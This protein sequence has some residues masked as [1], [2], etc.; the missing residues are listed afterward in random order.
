[1]NE[2]NSKKLSIPQKKAKISSKQSKILSISQIFKKYKSQDT[3]SITPKKFII[4]KN[5]TEENL[6][7][8]KQL[9][10][11]S[12]TNVSSLRIANPINEPNS[13]NYCKTPIHANNCISSCFLSEGLGNIK[14][15]FIKMMSDSSLQELDTEGNMNS[16]ENEN[17]EDIIIINE[18]KESTVTNDF[19]MSQINENTQQ[20]E[21]DISNRIP[22]VLVNPFTLSNSDEERKNNVKIDDNSSTTKK[23]SVESELECLQRKLLQ[24]AKR[25]DKDKV[26]TILQKILSNKKGDINYCDEN[27]WTAL[28]YASDEGCLKIVELLIKSNCDVNALTKN[29]KTALHLAS[30]HGYFDISRLL[31]ENGCLIN[32]Y[33]VEKNSPL[34]LCAFGGHEELLKFLLEKLPEA[35]TKNIYGNTPL[36]LACN[37]EIKEIFRKYLLKKENIYHRVKIHQANDSNLSQMFNNIKMNRGGNNNININIQNNFCNHSLTNLNTRTIC[38]KLHIGE[39]VNVTIKTSMENEIAP[40]TTKNKQAMFSKFGFKNNVIHSKN[41]STTTGDKSNQFLKLKIN[42]EYNRK[43]SNK[44]TTPKV[45]KSPRVIPS[46]TSREKPVTPNNIKKTNTN[47]YNGENSKVNSS[48]PLTAEIN[49]EEMKINPTSFICLALLGRGSFGEVYLVKKIDTNMLYAMKILSKNRIKSQNLFKYAMAERNVL[50]L[51][52]HPFIVKL[53]FAFQTS[54]KLFLILD[55]CSNGDL[56]RHLIYEKRFSE[57]RAKFYICE[58]LL[59]LEDLHQRGIIFRDLKPDNVV[60]DNEGH[61]KLTD[62]GLSKEG[63][64][65]S[66]CAK[67][68]CGSIAYLAPEMLKRSGHGKAV[69]WYLLGVLFYEML[70]GIPPFFTDQ[71]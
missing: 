34:H 45:E 67:S 56:S 61:A 11:N 17:E 54:N 43:F 7:S 16:I 59:A 32:Q 2:K 22:N 51:T 26:A 20:I 13:D 5:P 49:L 29:R 31:I 25:G 53:N 36:D 70:V 62:F 60:L 10:K 19:Y 66:D 14:S 42:T 47:G 3:Y 15:P 27:N 71:R 44:K 65:E 28:H 21:K 57:E 12:R 1:M 46:R 6:I 9:K 41:I 52:N 55:Y 40:K 38:K 8:Q 64:Y 18:Q 33:D 4:K 23:F 37:E 68:F 58:I 30:S 63:V 48:N 50:S 39:K 35:D 69:D 24:T